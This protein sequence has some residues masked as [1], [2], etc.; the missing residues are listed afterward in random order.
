M[1]DTG[2]QEKHKLRDKFVSEG[3]GQQS[4]TQLFCATLCWRVQ[5]LKN[6]SKKFTEH[7]FELR[8]QLQSSRGRKELICGDLAQLPVLRPVRVR[9]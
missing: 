1:D 6:A 7:D 2:M 5:G 4:D 8:M 3:Q 9:C